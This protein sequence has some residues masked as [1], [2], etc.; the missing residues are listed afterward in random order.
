M[1]WVRGQGWKWSWKWW[2]DRISR[3]LTLKDM[4]ENMTLEKE[5]IKLGAW[6]GALKPRLG[7]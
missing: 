1:D 4:A 3:K 2:G 6:A 5:T 7:S